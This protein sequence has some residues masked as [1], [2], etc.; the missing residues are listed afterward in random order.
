MC[1]AR[2][3]LVGEEVKVV[4]VMKDEELKLEE[5]GAA[6]RLEALLHLVYTPRARRLEPLTL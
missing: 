5:I 3:W 2:I 4:G 1:K 6:R